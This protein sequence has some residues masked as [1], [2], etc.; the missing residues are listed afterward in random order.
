ME[1]SV[2]SPTPAR[3]RACRSRSGETLEQVAQLLGVHKSTLLRWERGS[4]PKISRG[5][6]EK[7]AVHYGVSVHYLLGETMLEPPPQGLCDPMAV[8]LPVVSRIPVHVARLTEPLIERFEP[9]PK[10]ALTE[11]RQYLLLH[12]LDND[13][14]PTLQIHDL[15]LVE[16]GGT[17]ESDVLS[18]V[19]VDGW[20][21][22]IRRLRLGED[23]VELYSDNPLVVSRKYSGSGRRD[24]RI[25]GTVRR[26]IRCF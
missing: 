20:D 25:L 10:S 9:V 17:P 23:F 12:I 4:T 18:V 11:G 3:L 26:L 24:V 6:L 7:L 13:M 8:H 1:P 5:A 21:A 2:Y 19:A 14:A 16:M 15:A 22:V